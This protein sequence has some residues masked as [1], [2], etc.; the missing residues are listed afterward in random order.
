[1]AVMQD[2][3]RAAR[4][5]R[6]EYNVKPSQKLELA[7]MCNSPDMMQVLTT[8]K[9]TFEIL[10][11]ASAGLLRGYEGAPAPEACAV[12]VVNDS[13]SLYTRLAVRPA[14][15]CLLPTAG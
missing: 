9:D 6:S 5:V 15:R 2:V 7:V 10:A 8:H 13:A 12:H 4:A 11:N 3:L 14:P 1:M